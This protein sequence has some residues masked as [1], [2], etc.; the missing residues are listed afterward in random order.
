MNFSYVNIIS[1]VD[2]GRW[3]V[4][5]APACREEMAMGGVIAGH[6]KPN[7]APKGD[8]FRNW[9]G[10][11]LGL[12]LVGLVTFIGL[13]V[14]IFFDMTNIAMAYLLAVVITAVAAGLGPSVLVSVTSV[15]I[16]DFIFVPP[17]LN[18][19]PPEMGYIF[20]LL[21]SL[22][23]GVIISSLTSQVRRQT[24]KALQNEHQ[25]AVLYGLSRTLANS[26]GLDN[27]IRE[28]VSGAR[29]IL[30]KDAVIF[31]PDAHG[32]SRNSPGHRDTAIGTSESAAGLLPN[33]PAG[34]NGDARTRHFPLVSAGKTVGVLTIP[35][36]ARFTAEHERLLQ[37]FA[38][39]AAVSIERTQLAEQA[40]HAEVM[41]ATERLQTALLNSISHDLRTP[42]VSIIGVLTSLQEED[43]DLDDAAMK[44]LVQVA[45]EESERLNRLVTNLLD[46]SRIEAG[47]IRISR[48]STD[49]RDLI[50]AALEQLVRE[51]NRHPVHIDIPAQLPFVPVDSGLMVQTLVN[52]LDNAF[53][54][55][56][57]GSPIDITGR[58]AGGEVHIEVADR[59]T[60]IPAEDLA[61]VFD[62]FHRV[63]NAGNETG[64]GLGLS[65]CK[66]IVEAHGGRVA[67]ENRPG[68]GTVIRLVLP[69]GEHGP[70]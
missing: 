29:Q 40:R 10:Y 43:M 9:R 39:L 36:E 53:K 61:H 70:K 4:T 27:T 55:S 17:F 35:A 7:W 25:T 21:V 60:G 30:G 2:A 42:L 16:L 62:K 58:Q 65:I 28:I 44:S 1:A 34:P 8:S 41:K 54:Y 6:M 66:G 59:G 11:V 13:N 12:G 26:I 48:Q 24:Q 22:L 52:V 33:G 46:L 20:S 50:G 51:A 23:V 67:A 14:H 63:Q 56:S 49:V 38:D 32:P 64:T 19:G 45:R 31:L 37:A 5:A 57:P 68:G 47:A 18:L 3:S 15:I 69:A